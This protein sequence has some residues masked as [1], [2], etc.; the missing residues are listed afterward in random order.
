MNL[1]KKFK[2][3]VKISKIL[4]FIIL[5]FLIFYFFIN[6]LEPKV[7]ILKTF[8]HNHNNKLINKPDVKSNPL[9]NKE[10]SYLLNLISQNIGKNITNIH[11]LFL[12][13]NR[14]F[15]NQFIILN[16][17][18]FYCE[19]LGCK[20]I[21]LNKKY[22]WYIKH[23]IIN[24]RYKMIIDIGEEDNYKNKFTIFDNTYNFFY[25]SNIFRPEFK[26]NLLRKEI[27]RNLP[28]VKIGKNDLIIYIRSGDIFKKPNPCYSQ[29]P[30]CFYES[31]LNSTKFNNIYIISENKKNPVIDKIIEK[32]KNIIYNINNLK[33]DMSY[34][35]YAYNL[36]G[37]KTSFFLSTMLLNDNLNILYEYEIDF[38]NNKLNQIINSFNINHNAKIIYKMKASKKYNK[39][40]QNWNIKNDQLNLMLNDNCIN[41]F[42]LIYPKERKIIKIL[43]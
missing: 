34:I 33:Y 10:K 5:I 19:I 26:I 8:R 6:N 4:N 24:K 36:V 37:A 42:F 28:K 18:I 17:A 32:Y 9:L 7:I 22:F 11:T 14:R 35:I 40:M 3:I 1:F 2:N 25:Y 23:K 29:P 41:R 31:I 38:K 12:Q 16:K 21:I 39:L 13:H 20:K 15:G 43:K 30:L 27:I